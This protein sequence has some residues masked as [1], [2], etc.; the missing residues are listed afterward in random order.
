M[1]EFFEF[2][3]SNQTRNGSI[4]VTSHKVNINFC[5]MSLNVNLELIRA[6]KADDLERVSTMLASRDVDVNYRDEVNKLEI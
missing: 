6:A 4:T 2:F 1:F 3:E 5:A